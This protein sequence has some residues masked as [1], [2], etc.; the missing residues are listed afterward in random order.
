MQ[1]YRQKNQASQLTL[2]YLSRIV[3]NLKNVKLSTKEVKID[4]CVLHGAR[5]TRIV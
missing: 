4:F 2:K 3:F 5:F 1:D